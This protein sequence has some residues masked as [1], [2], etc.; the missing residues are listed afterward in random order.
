MRRQ[1]SKKDFRRLLDILEGNGFKLVREVGFK[2]AY[3]VV[4]RRDAELVYSGD[5]V[6]LIVK[7]SGHVIPF[8]GSIDMFSG[9]K[10]VYV[11]S[12]AVKPITN[13][14]DV[15]APGIK[16]GDFEAGDY[17][18]VFLESLN[19]PLAVGKALI[20]FSMLGE[21]G[22]AI[23]NIHYKGDKIWRYVFE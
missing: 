12:G 19:A 23:E 3:S 16:G 15:M 10:R 9:F 2:G 13:G 22:K 5:D 18:V 17:V 1:L 20:S 8:I 21:H 11:D 6:P 4:I 14:A 7:I